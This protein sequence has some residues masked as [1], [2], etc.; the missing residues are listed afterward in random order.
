[1]KERGIR[2]RYE[3]KLDLFC[4]LA[5]HH[6]KLLQELEPWPKV[7][8][9]I[10]DFQLLFHKVL[11]EGGFK[12]VEHNSLWKN[13]AKSLQL[14][15]PSSQEVHEALSKI[16]RKYL[17][18]LEVDYARRFPSFPQTETASQKK[19]NFGSLVDEAVHQNIG[20]ICAKMPVFALTEQELR[21]FFKSDQGLSYDVKENFVL[22]RN[23]ILLKFYLCPSKEL[24]LEE[25]IICPLLRIL[26]GKFVE[27]HDLTL[28]LK[29][30]HLYLIAGDNSKSSLDLFNIR[31]ICDIFYYL[32]SMG[33][34]NIGVFKSIPSSVS[35]FL[36]VPGS[37]T[38][39]EA[40]KP[41]KLAV[42]GAGLAG[43]GS[44]VQ[45]AKFGYDVHLHEASTREGGRV[46]SVE[47]DGTFA[48]LGAM[49]FTG[50]IGHPL[51]LMC[52]QL[53]IE[54]SYANK[55][56]CPLLPYADSVS[57]VKAMEYDERGDEE[58]YKFW[59]RILDKAGS[60]RRNEVKRLLSKTKTKK[61]K[62]PE[63]DSSGMARPEIELVSG[64][65]VEKLKCINDVVE[66]SH[67]DLDSL[68]RQF[69]QMMEDYPLPEPKRVK[70]EDNPFKLVSS[71]EKDVSLLKLIRFLFKEELRLIETEKT[72]K[73]KLRHLSFLEWHLAH[74]EYACCTN[75][76]NVSAL[77]WDQDDLYNENRAN[78]SPHC[79][80]K[81]GMQQLTK[82]L[83]HKFEEY[84]GRIFYNSRISRVNY[85]AER[86][87]VKK[88]LFST[89]AT[90]GAR[91]KNGIVLSLVNQSGD[92]ENR[93]YAGVIITVSLGVLQA[94][95]I[96][97]IPRLPDWKEKSINKVGFG[98][99]N[100][101]IMYFPYIFWDQHSVFGKIKFP[102]EDFIVNEETNLFDN[103]DRG[104]MFQFLP[105]SKLN[106]GKPM[107]MALVAGTAAEK[108]IE[109]RTTN[110]KLFLN[111]IRKATKA[112][113]SRRV[114]KKH[115]NFKPP[116]PTKVLVSDWGG[117]DLIKGSYTYIKVGGSGNDY[118][119]IAE[120]VGRNS[121]VQFAGEATSREYPTTVHGAFLS[122]LKESG[123][124]VSLH[125]RK[126]RKFSQ[127]SVLYFLQENRKYI[128][129]MLH[130]RKR[131]EEVL[132]PSYSPN[133]NDLLSINKA[134]WFI[135]SHIDN[136][137]IEKK[138]K[139][140]EASEVSQLQNMRYQT[141]KTQERLRE[142][143]DNHESD[144]ETIVDFVLEGPDA[145]VS[146]IKLDI[147]MPKMVSFKEH[148]PV[149]F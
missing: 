55:A 118:T 124:T 129:S 23:H 141:R 123:R 132:K 130:N 54:L 72:E 52:K 91:V 105:Q 144:D 93:D 5:L 31:L 92:T 101:I 38:P 48:E 43:L 108:L 98:L 20:A 73:L 149:I 77:K 106:D 138:V 19:F 27:E 68:K 24:F 34:I 115:P 40:E 60:G 104:E 127:P 10:V 76:D 86:A 22:I 88:G 18:L 4:H 29:T 21:I 143:F 94:N 57:E 58:M 83:L 145:T 30:G 56:L 90:P 17:L 80:L 61:F 119:N 114:L 25:D 66:S 8:N 134:A 140:E 136:D 53:N 84:N 110:P 112:I 137:E 3:S 71:K 79:Y 125:G 9:Q 96:G 128:A 49:V 74:L 81:G 33:K 69:D 100:K 65:E 36:F 11:R 44:A 95:S 117:D 82:A 26:K 139:D 121:C 103:E 120:P 107:L 116:Y 131:K 16:Y 12:Y 35:D 15:L 146:P 109:L 89:K 99:L 70:S 45:L 2:S 67:G 64:T 46:L 41:P 28:G 97:F 50:I 126:I 1:M 142:K 113:V 7:N 122:S 47:I 32:D 6:S 42:V 39:E 135:D 75:L 37:C 148:K 59:N 14:N 111:K 102:L 51:Y 133:V 62:A 85:H 63:P 78:E 13:V 87:E 147:R